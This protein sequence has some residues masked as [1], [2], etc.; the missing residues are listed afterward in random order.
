MPH[1]SRGG[2]RGRTSPVVPSTRPS[3]RRGTG[4]T[5]SST[6]TAVGTPNSRARMA[7]WERKLPVSDTSPPSRGS[8]GARS[9]SSVRTTR[10][11]PASGGAV[12]AVHGPRAPAAAGAGARAG[13]ATARPAGTAR[14]GRPAGRGDRAG[15]RQPE[16]G[17]QRCAALRRRPVPPRRP[18]RP[19]CAPLRRA[20]R[21]RSQRTS[22]ASAM[23][24]E[25]PGARPAPRRPGRSA[26]AASGPAGAGPPAGRR[27]GRAPVVSSAVPA[28]PAA[29]P[30]PAAGRRPADPGG[31]QGEHARVAE[32]DL[33][34]G[35]SLGTGRRP[36]PARPPRRRWSPAGGVGGDQPAQEDLVAV[37]GGEALGRAV[38][39]AQQLPVGEAVDGVD[40][41]EVAV[42]LGH[43]VGGQRRQGGPQP[44]DP[45]GRHQPAD[46]RAGV[47]ACGQ[48]RRPAQRRASRSRS[49]ATRPADGRD[50]R[51]GRQPARGRRPARASAARSPARSGSTQR[52]SSSG[53]QR[54]GKR[55]GHR[56]GAQ[57]RARCVRAAPMAV[58]GPALEQPQAAVGVEGPLDVLRPAEDPLGPV[59]EGPAAGAAGSEVSG[60]APAPSTT[61]PAGEHVAGAVDLAAH[62]RRRPRPRWPTRRRGRSGLR[63][64]RRRT[65]PRRRWPRAGAG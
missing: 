28:P 26:P 57:R 9:G 11:R 31:H 42:D 44:A 65:A 61:A 45:P 7:R 12:A 1:R 8:S 35:Q 54:L 25:T 47:E 49:A 56:P 30:W 41:Q 53:R 2:R 18:A 58:T 22:P 63:R 59:G 55:L 40:G 17:R 20:R 39:Q 60:P 24:P 10:T 46:R 51:R 6:P 19:R 62:D 29:G 13:P 36:G 15:R 50:H 4:S 52:S 34:V 27:R 43:Q 48:R 21:S 3:C 14:V 32:D 37:E 16:P 64:G 5:A 23:V 33:G 38:E